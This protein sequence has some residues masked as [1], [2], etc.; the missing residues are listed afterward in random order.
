M[1]ENRGSDREDETECWVAG[2][3]LLL[4]VAVLLPLPVSP[5]PDVVLL[6]RAGFVLLGANVVIS[7][8]LG[9]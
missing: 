6:L 9:P 2:V 7:R 4:P 1:R 3:V 8:F 5:L